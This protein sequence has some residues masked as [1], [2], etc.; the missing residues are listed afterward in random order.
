MG[1]FPLTVESRWELLSLK[2]REKKRL[3][4]RA[5]RECM[6][7]SSQSMIQGGGGTA[8]ES[9]VQPA[10]FASAFRNSINPCGFA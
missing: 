4:M 1:V 10:C 3:E 9:R 2:P 6:L 7:Q 5:P 8:V